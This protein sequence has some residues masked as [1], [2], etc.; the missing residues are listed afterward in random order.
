ML[1]V[2]GL[3]CTIHRSEIEIDK[4]KIPSKHSSSVMTPAPADRPRK[5]A[6][7]WKKPG[8]R[9]TTAPTSVTSLTTSPPASA[10]QKTICSCPVEELHQFRT[11]KAPLPYQPPYISGFVLQRSF[12]RTKIC[13]YRINADFVKMFSCIILRFLRWP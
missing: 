12:S 3:S 11:P 4:Q 9:L 13:N 5:T 1:I 6:V 10:S 2:R 7:P 8:T